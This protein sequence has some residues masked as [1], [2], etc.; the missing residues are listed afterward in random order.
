MRLT[1]FIDRKTQKKIASFPDRLKKITD[2]YLN[3]PS[4]SNFQFGL[5]SDR[6][7]QHYKEEIMAYGLNLKFVKTQL[8]RLDAEVD[9]QLEAIRQAKSAL[10]QHEENDHSVQHYKREIECFESNL[11]LT[12]AQISRLIA[13]VDDQL[14]VV[15]QAKK[16]IS[17]HE[18]LQKKSGRP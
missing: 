17:Q 3:T 8:S 1:D 15:D 5:E 6:D 16:T 12:K 7:V 11:S 13:E 2:D 4:A 9:G 10:G 14:R 18:E